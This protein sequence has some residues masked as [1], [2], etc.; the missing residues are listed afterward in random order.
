VA[1]LMLDNWTL[2][3]AFMVSNQIPQI[4][5]SMEPGSAIEIHGLP[6]KLGLLGKFQRW[7]DWSDGCIALTDEEIDELYTAVK[8]KHQLKSS[9][10]VILNPKKHLFQY[11]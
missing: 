9:H 1:E 2:K 8:M 4:Y 6:K 10:K 7:H 3:I 5:E 11:Y